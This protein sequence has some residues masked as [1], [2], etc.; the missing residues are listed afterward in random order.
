[1]KKYPIILL[2]L[3]LVLFACCKPEP[4]EPKEPGW[5]KFEGIYNVTKL[6][7]QEMYQVEISFDSLEL[8]N[9]GGEIDLHIIYENFDDSF[10]R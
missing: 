10:D 4:I 2:L 1:M 9:S 3:P 6:E 7:N 8:P 5:K